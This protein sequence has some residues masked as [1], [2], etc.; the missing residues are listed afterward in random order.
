MFLL[1]DAGLYAEQ[2]PDCFADHES[3]VALQGNKT[4]SYGEK[5]DLPLTITVRRIAPISLSSGK[6]ALSALSKMGLRTV[7]SQGFRC[8][9]AH[10]GLDTPN[11]RVDR[12]I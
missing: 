1:H 5:F 2:D 8:Q 7:L 3:G 10:C 9:S 11:L 12:A 6:R 4:T